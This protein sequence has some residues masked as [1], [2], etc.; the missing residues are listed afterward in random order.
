MYY[1][2][3]QK[4][5]FLFFLLC[6][7]N[8]SVEA[9][10]TFKVQTD[11]THFQPGDTV[12]FTAYVP[13]WANSKRL[14]T[15]QLGIEDVHHQQQWKLRYP[16]LK[17][18]TQASIVL[19]VTLPKDVYALHFSIQPEFFLLEGW[20]N[21]PNYRGDSIK[22][23][24]VLEGN[25]IA[26]GNV[27]LRPDKSFTLG[28]VLFENQ[29]NL[30]FNYTKPKLRNLLS[31]DIR[32]PLDSAFQS[33]AD[34]TIML[35]VG[36]T[37]DSLGSD[38]QFNNGSNSLNFG[39]TLDTVEVTAKIKTPSEKFEA[40]HVNGMFRGA[41]ARSFFYLDSEGGFAGWNN[42]LEWLRAKVAGLVVGIDPTLGEYRVT[43]RGQPTAVFLDEMPVDVNTLSL[44]SPTNI[45][46]VKVFRPPF[47][48]AFF[49]GIG[50]AI[51]V[52]TKSGDG[53]S[54]N[55]PRNRF[56]VSGYTPILFTLPQQSKE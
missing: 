8:F 19:P 46:L 14:A 54:G 6:C 35:S 28:R 55:T 5:K 43:W 24:M 16:L 3:F 34:T 36:A 27:V 41:S 50:G 56:L 2:I 47:A 18:I 53:E 13:Q 7:F 31:I 20:V 37:F 25:E 4:A 9:Q 30:F 15:L 40:E 52:Y 38:Y 45:A 22:Y 29:A 32:T 26:T 10:L 1:P 11:T 12:A 17:G 21:T 42:I 23:T 39:T 33:L 51:V 49:G 48:G 44:V